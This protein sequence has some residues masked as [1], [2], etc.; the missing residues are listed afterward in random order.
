M[1]W[2]K[3]KKKS[4]NCH[5]RIAAAATTPFDDDHLSRER[6]RARAHE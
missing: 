5:G 3:K 2:K 1:S 6:V 4:W